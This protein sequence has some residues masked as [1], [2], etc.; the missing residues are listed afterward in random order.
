[1]EHKQVDLMDEYRTINKQ[2]GEVFTKQELRDLK[3]LLILGLILYRQQAKL[4]P[5]MT[6]KFLDRVGKAL[7]KMGV[8]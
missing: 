5:G 8:C 6:D 3:D 4:E 7:L 2:L 1:M